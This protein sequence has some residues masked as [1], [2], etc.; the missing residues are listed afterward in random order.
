MIPF[1]PD[2]NCDCDQRDDQKRRD[3][4]T[5]EPIV[6]LAAIEPNLETCEA[7]CNERNTDMVNLQ[8][9]ALPKPGAVPE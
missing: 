3:Q 8:A 4:M 7:D 2:R 6:A 1:P 9:A 5:A